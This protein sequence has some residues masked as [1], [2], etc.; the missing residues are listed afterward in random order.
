MHKHWLMHLEMHR[1]TD[2]NA[3]ISYWG[4]PYHRCLRIFRKD[5]L[6]PSFDLFD[7]CSN[8]QTCWQAFCLI[9]LDEGC[10]NENSELKVWEG[11]MKKVKKICPF[12]RKKC[13]QCALYRGRH[14][15]LCF[16]VHFQNTKSK[17]ST[18]KHPQTGE[19]EEDYGQVIPGI[20]LPGTLNS[21]S[22]IEGI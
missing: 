21:T 4:L 3:T 19:K 17:K 1:M 7:D 11:N 15:N 22:D 18:N 9:P 12:T 6:H 20:L 16:S 8:Y 13:V 10:P 2:E 5:S 14:H